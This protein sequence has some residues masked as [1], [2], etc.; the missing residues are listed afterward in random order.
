[1]SR[2]E[3]LVLACGVVF[4]VSAVVGYVF[5]ESLSRSVR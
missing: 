5:A 2:A 1:M 4:V 3:L